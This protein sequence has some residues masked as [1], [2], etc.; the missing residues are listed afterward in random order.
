MRFASIAGIVLV[1]WVLIGAAAAGQRGYLSSGD[2]GC[3]SV[4]TTVVTILT[5]P[6]NYMGANPK[7]QNCEA[8]QP[9]K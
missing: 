6:L 3:A 8:P 5:G 9:S 2:E 7:V 4:G 1:L